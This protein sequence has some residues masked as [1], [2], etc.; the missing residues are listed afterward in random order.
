MPLSLELD[1]SFRKAKPV[2]FSIADENR[3]WC[4]FVGCLVLRYFMYH[5]E[6]PPR[7]AKESK[8]SNSSAS[9]PSCTAGV[10]GVGE[11]HT[12]TGLYMAQVWKAPLLFRLHL[13]QQLPAALAL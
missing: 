10:M 4:I 13:D 5:V 3:I 12:H 8:A 6:Q 9:Y 11:K 2:I 7:T 1:A